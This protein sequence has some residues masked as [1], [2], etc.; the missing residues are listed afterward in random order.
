MTT[1]SRTY[2]GAAVPLLGES[3]IVQ[4]TAATDILTIRQASAS[5]GDALV[6]RNSSSTNIFG[7]NSYGWIRTMVMGTVALAQC[8]SNASATAA[9][10]GATTDDI[11]HFFPTSLGVVTGNGVPRA[12][13]HTADK[14]TVFAQ[15]GS[16]AAQTACV[17]LINTAGGA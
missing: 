6:V 4:K 5:S 2:E 11:I 1:G 17:L 12:Y 15:G 16:F 9:L 13:V 8:A 10:S 3:E 14:F 7:V